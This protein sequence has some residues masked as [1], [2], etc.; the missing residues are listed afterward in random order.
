MLACPRC[1]QE[2][3]DIARFCLACAAPLAK[4]AAG[5]EERRIVSVVFVD[6]VGFTLRAERLD[7]E[8]VRAML[9]PY[10]ASVRSEIERFGG[11]VEKF[12]GDAVM[13][14]FGAPVAYGDDAERAVRAAL[15]VR[16]WARNN[17]LEIRTAVN[18]GEAIVTLGD[19]TSEGEGM[20][21][22][23][24]VNTAAR[25]Q[26]SAPVLG[27]LVGDETYRA[28]RSA[29]EYERVE[30]IDAKGKA[31]P[32]EAWL[33]VA[34]RS[35]EGDRVLS[36][37]PMVGRARELDALRAVWERV[38][39]ER[40]PQLVTVFGPSGMGKSRLGAEFSDFVSSTR[41]RAIRGRCIPYGASM[42]Y[43]P[44]AQLVKQVAGIFESDSLADAN[45]KL[46]SA[47]RDL[48][49][50]DD[51]EGVATHVALL[52]GLRT[53]VS[54]PDRETLF[55]SARLLA[56]ALAARE[57]TLLV[58]EDIH[59]GDAS[60]LDLIE[61]L[62]ARAGDVPL[63]LLTLTRPEL[64]TTRP[65]W[66]GGLRVYTAI[67]LDRLADDEA[68][69]LA[70]R[71]LA[72]HDGGRRAAAVAAVAATAEGNPLFVEELA[73]SLAEHTTTAIDD[74]PTSIRAIVAARLD[75][76]PSR[77]RAVLRDA[78]VMGRIFWRGA[79]QRLGHT[80]GLSEVLGSLEQRDLVRREAVSRIQ[81]EQQF[82]FK[83][84][85]IRDVA[86]QRLP[87]AERRERHA[88]VAR[89]LEETTAESGAAPGALAHHW[90]EA[91]DHERAAGYLVAA[92]DRAG[93]GWAKER[94]ASLYREALEL[95]P[96]DDPRRRDIM[97]KLA[98]AVQAAF[99]VAD[100]QQLRRT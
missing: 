22:G 32:V 71:L 50:W 4:P 11:T 35:A 95:L 63:L 43:G 16:D 99:H 94:A 8:D 47:L 88:T 70:E 9:S 90:R 46:V 40:R 91:G 67:T 17:D 89:F 86:Y 56:E 73:A 96:P 12:V 18:T 42:P 79:L 24:V 49:A 5:A 74:L 58:F 80:N 20:V 81:G 44:F 83:H 21:A 60:L 65:A 64:L 34:P 1:G 84:V 2:N 25:L 78:S 75:A 52:T 55:F 61:Y 23:D 29:I 51:I 82:T 30:P 54:V 68:K 36:N 48:A 26:T 77:E 13:G 87:R 59:W 97:R 53:D 37:V 45:D 38:V 28:T 85:L 66:A 72:Q 62:A 3:P 14:V 76:L 19:R 57:P 92:G 100:A 10:Y 93:M 39:D 33:A 41:G 31:A 69:E 27:V 7:P 15:A 98:V 6:L